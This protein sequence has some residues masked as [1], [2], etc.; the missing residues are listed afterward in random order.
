MVEGLVPPIGQAVHP[1]S[2]NPRLPGQTFVIPA[3]D[4]ADVV[5]APVLEDLPDP[6]LHH[7]TRPD[8]SVGHVGHLVRLPEL[9]AAPLPL[10]IVE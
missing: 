4:D 9:A 6:V 8:P 1:H 7:G 10:C 5:I 2:A 3:G